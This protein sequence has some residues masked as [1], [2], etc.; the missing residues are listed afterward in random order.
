M[1]FY[2]YYFYWTS[3][4]LGVGAGLLLSIFLCPPLAWRLGLILFIAGLIGL[5]YLLLTSQLQR[6]GAQQAMLYR[7]GSFGST[8][9]YLGL[10]FLV[11]AV[12]SQVYVIR[13]I[14][15][16]CRDGAVPA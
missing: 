11:I 12:T 10:V 8:P 7:L 15:H 13:R 1:L 6:T 14:N 9:S 5:P 16:Y 3:L 2:C 4:L